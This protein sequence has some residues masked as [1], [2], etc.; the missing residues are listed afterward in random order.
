MGEREHRSF[1]RWIRGTFWGRLCLVA[2]GLAT[3]LT[4]F[5]FV[6]GKALPDFFP[7]PAVSSESSASR[8]AHPE[9]EAPGGSTAVLSPAPRPMTVSLDGR[10]QAVTAYEIE[11]SGCTGDVAKISVTSPGRSVVLIQLALDELSPRGRAVVAREGSGSAVTVPAVGATSLRVQLTG[12]E[13]MFSL[14]ATP[15]AGAD[16]A[17]PPVLVVVH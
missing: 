6:T 17:S 14:E 7:Q 10:L 1:W 5:G 2:G 12:G 13:G 15:V 4:I 11:S 9:D 3:F 16:C 8:T